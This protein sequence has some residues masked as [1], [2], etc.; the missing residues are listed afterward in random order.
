[1]A[2][3]QKTKQKKQHEQ[4]WRINDNDQGENQQLRPQ[5]TKLPDIFKTNKFLQVGQKKRPTTPQKTGH[6]GSSQEKELQTALNHVKSY[7]TSFTQNKK[8]VKQ[9]YTEKLFLPIRLVQIPNH[10]NIRSAGWW[11]EG[12]SHTLLVGLLIK[13]VRLHAGQ[14]GHIDQC[15]G[16]STLSPNNCISG[17]LSHRYVC[18]YVKSQMYRV[19]HCSILRSSKTLETT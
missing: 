15:Y 17:N 2:Q 14:L 10:G 4:N 9:N 6:L 18:T 19:T 1:M 11:G 13:L 3:K 7:A 5:R 12:P 8:N 16:R